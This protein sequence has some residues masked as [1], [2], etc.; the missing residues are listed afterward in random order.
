MLKFLKTGDFPPIE[1]SA[2]LNNS[3]IAVTVLVVCW[4]ITLLLGRAIRK[5]HSQ[6]LKF[7]ALLLPIITSSATFLIFIIGFVIILDIF[8]VNTNSIVALLGASGLAIAFA[9]KDTLQNIAAGFMLLLLRP[10]TVGDYI[11]CGSM[12][13]TI[14][15]VH[16]FTT[17]LE[18]PDGLYISAPN[19]ALWGC[20]IKN[21]TRNGK[22][23]LDAVVGISYEDSIDTGIAV[24]Q[25]I[26]TKET[27]FLNDPA[28][29]VMVK[30]LEDSFVALQIRAWLLVA[31]FSA[32]DWDLNRLM[33]EKIEAAGL[34][35]PFPQRDI[36]MF[37]HSPTK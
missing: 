9:L 29:I 28:P 13:G 35:I 4:I 37:Q 2:I 12:T 7:D 1:H 11:E 3:L 18:T 34:T 17:I 16:V 22:R 24:L 20:S 6:F 31:D 5:A 10:F 8:G 23:R 36:H 27:R 32:V 14:K 30:A 25:E 33:K 15:E 26:I 21:Y 19:S